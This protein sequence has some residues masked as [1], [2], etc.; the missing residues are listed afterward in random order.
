MFSMASKRYTRIYD[1]G[2]CGDDVYNDLPVKPQGSVK[3]HRPNSLFV[4]SVKTTSLPNRTSKR[5][6]KPQ[7]EVKPPQQREKEEFK[8]ELAELLGKYTENVCWWRMEEHAEII[9]EITDENDKLT[10]ENDKLSREKDKLSRENDRLSIDND[11]LQSIIHKMTQR[12]AKVNEKKDWLSRRE[13]QQWACDV[14][15]D[16]F[17]LDCA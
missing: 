12:L 8:A 14:P 10:S 3:P 13:C 7:K 4:S 11:K 5:L 16:F 6:I 2:L 17:G 1:D 9:E 15:T